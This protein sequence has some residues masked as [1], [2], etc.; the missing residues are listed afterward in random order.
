MIKF[1]K[2]FFKRETDKTSLILDWETIVEDFGEYGKSYE[3][4]SR[5]G[6][7]N[8]SVFYD[9]DYGTRKYGWK[10][11]IRQGIA[12]TQSGKTFESP[13]KA[14]LSC[15]KYVKNGHFKEYEASWGL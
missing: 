4:K 6:Q 10:W 7:W 3:H 14:K 12:Y 2:T 8:L 9:V 11:R 13:E 1:F 15:E 5:Y